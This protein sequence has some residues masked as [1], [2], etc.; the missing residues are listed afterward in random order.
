MNSPPPSLILSGV[1][2]SSR[3][4][5]V[6]LRFKASS[7]IESPEEYARMVDAFVLV[8][9]QGGFPAP[10]FAPH[11]ASLSLGA[12]ATPV[13]GVPA[14]ELHSNVLDPRAFQVLRNMFARQTGDRPSVE[15]ILVSDRQR[16]DAP[17]IIVPVADE[18]NEPDVYPGISRKIPFAV[19][20]E[21]SEF[22]KVR[23]FLIEMR[24]PVEPATVVEVGEWTKP[25]SRILEAGGFGPPVC[26]A[27]QPG[28]L[29]GSITQFDEITLEFVVNRFIAS[30]CSWNVLINM[31]DAY[32]HSSILV[33]RIIID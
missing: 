14:F 26:E 17:S 25:W 5:D 9:A 11:Q 33:S 22:G 1:S 8:G 27:D 31:L 23:R 2:S 7:Q 13:P 21:Q 32:S 18:N 19:E 30:E 24:T 3:T 15:A 29:V 10:G 28:C 16:R 4:L 20:W 6:K 12:G